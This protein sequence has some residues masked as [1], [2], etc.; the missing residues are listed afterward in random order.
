MKSRGNEAPI[1]ITPRD[2]LRLVGQIR[3]LILGRN[4]E[5]TK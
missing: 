1:W 4:K 2:F 3:D 5:R